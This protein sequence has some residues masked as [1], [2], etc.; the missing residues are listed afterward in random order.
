VF[1]IL[2]VGEDEEATKFLNDLHNN[3]E[4]YKML[5]CYMDKLDSEREVFKKAND[6]LAYSSFVSIF[7]Y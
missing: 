7:L 5:Y 1:L 6:D 2:R 4:L 3:E